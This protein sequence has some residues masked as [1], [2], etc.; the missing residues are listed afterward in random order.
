[1]SG[2]PVDPWTF[3]MVGNQIY[4]M[5]LDNSVVTHTTRLFANYWAQDH[6]L[7]HDVTDTLVAPAC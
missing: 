6:W 3:E 2:D 1:M 7:F 5:G 4:Q